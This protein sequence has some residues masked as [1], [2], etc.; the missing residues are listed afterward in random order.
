MKKP[1]YIEEK[2]NQNMPGSDKKIV[3]RIK[4][5]MLLG[6]IYDQLMLKLRYNDE[7]THFL[8]YGKSI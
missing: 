7:K 1:A 4:D 6:T 8:Y 5:R 2:G 3:N